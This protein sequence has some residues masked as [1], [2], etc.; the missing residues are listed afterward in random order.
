VIHVFA[1]HFSHPGVIFPL[2]ISGAQRSAI[3]D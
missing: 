1:I 2:V 3:F